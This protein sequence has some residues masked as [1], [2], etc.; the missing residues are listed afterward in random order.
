MPYGG[1]GLPEDPSALTTEPCEQRGEGSSQSSRIRLQREDSALPC[2]H[3][4]S[5]CGANCVRRETRLGR[6]SK[7]DGPDVEIHTHLW[8]WKK[9]VKELI[10]PMALIQIYF[11]GH[12]KEG[13]RL[14]LPS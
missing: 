5:L 6:L 12:L 2:S 13:T 10:F 1:L 9:N 14:S 11:S 8:R 4:H 7:P 3:S